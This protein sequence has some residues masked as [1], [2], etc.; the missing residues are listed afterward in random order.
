VPSL[1]RPAAAV[2]IASL[3]AAVVA[4]AADAAGPPARKPLGPKEREAILALLKAVDHAQDADVLAE[5]GVAWTHHI[6]K[7]GKQSAYVPFRVTL[8]GAAMK[9]PAVYVRAVSRRDGLRARDEHSILR[10]WVLKGGDVPARPGETVYVGLG[11]MPVGG[12]AISSSRQSTA[13]AAAASSALAMQQRAYE[14]EKA[15]AEAAKQKDETPQRDPF[16]FPFEDYH[17]LDQKAGAPI[18][19]A[20]ALPPGE[21]DVFVAVIDRDRLK[22]SSALVTRRTIAV[23]DFWD[24]RLT[25]SS[26]I[27]ARDVRTLKTPLGGGQQVE[28]PYTFG[29]AEVVPVAAAAFTQDDALTVV[30]QICNYG[31]PDADLTADYAFYRTD[32]T[33]RLFNHTNP[34]VFADGDLPPPGA[35]ET[36]AFAS[37]TV[38]LAPFPPGEYELEVSVR[39]RLTRGSAKATVAFTVSSGVR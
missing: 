28:H 17:L 39:D 32:G 25:L 35:W 15:A 21:Y 13:A 27:L 9:A 14:K 30:Y 22:T 7:G 10:D 23:P 18:E 19:R 24:D 29:H 31:A 2:V 8:G 4:I 33:R 6:L 3:L 16:L 38:P 5:E 34:Q 36:A 37:Q 12:P 20:L 11:E 26:L 1:E